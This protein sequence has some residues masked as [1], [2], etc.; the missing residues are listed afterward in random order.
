MATTARWR[1]AQRNPT[2]IRSTQLCYSCKVPWEPDHR[3]RGKDQKHTIE[4]HY[5]SDDEVCED[6]AIDVDLGAV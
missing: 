6:G 5:D 1:E 2:P 4:A 3:C